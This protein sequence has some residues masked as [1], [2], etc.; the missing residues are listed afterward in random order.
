MA[1]E[2]RIFVPVSDETLKRIDQKAKQDQRSKAFVSAKALEKAF[3]PK[4]FKLKDVSGDS[5]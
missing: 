3:Q 5:L 2:K 4:D 1:K